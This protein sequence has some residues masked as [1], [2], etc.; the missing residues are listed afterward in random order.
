[1]LLV[2]AHRR[3][4]VE[5][6][7]GQQVGQL[8]LA[9]LQ[10]AEVGFV[11]QEVEDKTFTARPPVPPGALRRRRGT[12]AMPSQSPRSAQTGRRSRRSPSA[13]DHAPI[14][15]RPGIGETMLPIP[16]MPTAHPIP[17]LPTHAPYTFPP[18]PLNP[19]C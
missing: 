16:P 7:L 12:L 5:M 11:S 14:A 15:S 10:V 19:V 13:A 17:L 1:M 6:A 2:G 18:A 3:P 9:A 4:G 8:G